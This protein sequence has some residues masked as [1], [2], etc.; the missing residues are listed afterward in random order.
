MKNVELEGSGLKCDNKNCDWHDKSISFSDY[1]KWLNAPCPKCG[2]NV[3][4]EQDYK[5]SEA[6]RKAVDIVNAMSPEELEQLNELSKKLGIDIKD[7]PM[8]QGAIG[9]DTLNTDAEGR[10]MQKSIHIKKLK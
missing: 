10:V 9:L 7:N 8:F 4:T 2:E 3:L 1:K 6:L 5:N